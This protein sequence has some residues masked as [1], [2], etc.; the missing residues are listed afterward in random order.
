MQ[1]GCCHTG[2]HPVSRFTH[3][4]DVVKAICDRAALL[5]KGRLRE[6]FPVASTGTRSLPTYYEQVKRELMS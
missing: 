1:G 5:E 2:L 4:L 6:V 3:D